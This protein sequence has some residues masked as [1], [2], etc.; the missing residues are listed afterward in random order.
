MT[1]F[2]MLMDVLASL[3]ALV[4]F[5]F[6]VEALRTVPDKPEKLSWAPEIP[7]QYLLVDGMKLRLI[8]TGAGRN[9]VLLHTLRTQLDLFQ[10]MVLDL[11]KY[12]T[13]YALDYPGHGYSDIPNSKYDADFLFTASKGFWTPWTCAMFFFAGCPSA[14]P[15]V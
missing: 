3:V 12:F 5:S 6:I 9:L 13:V 2:E 10:R 7:I 14:A 1:P 15:S 4:V 8:K 11:A